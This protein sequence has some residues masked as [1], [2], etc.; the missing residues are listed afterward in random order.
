[1]QKHPNHSIDER[2]KLVLRRSLPAERW[3]VYDISPDYCKDN[4]VELVED[5]RQTGTSFVVQLKGK[6]MRSTRSTTCSSTG[7]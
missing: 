6:R 2:A 7:R 5:G 1:M 3:Q 4:E